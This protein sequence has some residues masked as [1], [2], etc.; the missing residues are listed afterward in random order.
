MNQPHTRRDFLRGITYAG[1]ALSLSARSYS[2]ALGANSDIRVA[3]VGIN[4]RGKEHISE[5]LQCPGARIT[6]LC[7]VDSL[8]LDAGK[9]RLAEKGH[10]V[11]CYTD[12]RKLLEDGEVDVV[13]LATP[14]HWHA[15]GAI[16]AIQAGKDVYV[17]KP[18]SHNVWEGRQLVKAA[19]KHKKIVQSGTQSRSSTGLREA[20]AWAKAGNLGKVQ[21]ARGTCYKRRASI[22]H[23][24]SEQPWP[25]HIDKDLWFGPAP[26]KPI[27]RARLH[28]DW[29]WCWDTGNGDLGNQ[30]VHQMDIAR[31][32]LGE[33]ALSPSV[34][35][36]GG[37]LGYSDD[38]ETPNTMVVI[39]GYEKAPLYFEVR[40]LPQKPEAEPALEKMDQYRGSSVG[41]IV[42]YEGGHLLIPSYTK[43]EAFDKEG[44]KIREWQGAESHFGNFLKAVR[45]RNAAD[46]NA[47]VLEGH[48]SAALC[49][50]GNISYRMGDKAD[51]KVIREKVKADSEAVDSLERMIEHL[52]RN[53]IAHDPLV[54]GE[55]LKMNPQKETFVRNAKADL[56]LTREYRKG[57]SI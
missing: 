15:L 16:W 53:Q 23:V 38:G 6:A 22:G 9:A 41:V 3:V 42:Q 40:G 55:F 46:L 14:N 10:Q 26:I 48:V 2:A 27:R 13:T 33:S 31:W 28:Y 50:T 52:G 56:L 54:L 51:V 29:H 43:A 25:A 5:I 17:E 35:S 36:V 34:M 1:A 12:I 20:L 30:G 57:F 44:K 4:G 24:E 8:V 39:H 32:F 49:H 21:W 45:S 37:R 47:E 19:R 18:I 7:D 11:K